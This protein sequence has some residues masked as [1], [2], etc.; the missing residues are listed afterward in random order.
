MVTNAGQSGA[1]RRAA[2]FARRTANGRISSGIANG[3][4]GVSTLLHGFDRNRMRTRAH[5]LEQVAATPP[6][7]RIRPLSLTTKVGQLAPLLLSASVNRVALP[8]L[9]LTSMLTTFCCWPRLRHSSSASCA[10]RW[11][12]LTR[13]SDHY[14]RTTLEAGKNPPW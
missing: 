9:T 2:D 8:S 14:P 7:L 13:Y 5:R 10:L 4:G 1:G 11:N 12:R 3:V 6:L